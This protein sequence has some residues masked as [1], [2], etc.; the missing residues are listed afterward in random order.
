MPQKHEDAHAIVSA[1]Y[2]NNIDEARENLRNVL[3]EW[4]SALS[5]EKI[6]DSE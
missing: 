2:A 4:E 5:A 6:G 3:N 1:F